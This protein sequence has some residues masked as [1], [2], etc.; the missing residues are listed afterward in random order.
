MVNIIFGL[1]KYFLL[2]FLLHQLYK[3]LTNGD[4]F[5]LLFKFIF[6]YI[7]FFVLCTLLSSANSAV[8]LL[9]FINSAFW[10]EKSVTKQSMSIKLYRLIIVKF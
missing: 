2:F 5:V 3:M 10:Q 1:Y 7:A 4:N 9:F 8:Y 6:A